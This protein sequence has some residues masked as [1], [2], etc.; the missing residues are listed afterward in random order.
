MGFISKNNRAVCENCGTP[1]LKAINR[2]IVHCC[3]EMAKYQNKIDAEFKELHK[4]GERMCIEPGP[5]I[6]GD[7]DEIYNTKRTNL[8][9]KAPFR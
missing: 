4:P 8:K 7:P 6:P 1:L 3:A 2:R 5:G 9:T